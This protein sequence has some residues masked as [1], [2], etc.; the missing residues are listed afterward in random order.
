MTRWCEL[1]KKCSEGGR[2]AKAGGGGEV[3]NTSNV[4]NLQMLII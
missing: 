1:T 2:T 3:E 4:V